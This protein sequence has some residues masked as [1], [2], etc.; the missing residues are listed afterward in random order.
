MRAAG[1]ATMTPSFDTATTRAP[2][3]ND[4]TQASNRDTDNN[5][6]PLNQRGPR[7][8][9]NP[10]TTPTG[11][12]PRTRTNNG[13]TQPSKTGGQRRNH[14]DAGRPNG[15]KRRVATE[16]R[17]QQP[18]KTRA[19]KPTEP[20]TKQPRNNGVNRQTDIETGQH[21]HRPTNER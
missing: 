8:G 20:Q 7:V 9:N 3:G 18:T 6:G 5:D 10:A 1:H 11:G 16:A 19:E 21:G 12:P 4:T 15:R 14:N 13:T 17:S 2:R